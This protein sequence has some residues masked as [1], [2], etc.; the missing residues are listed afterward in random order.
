MFFKPF[1]VL[2]RCHFLK[3]KSKFSKRYIKKALFALIKTV[4]T[5]LLQILPAKRLNAGF[6]QDVRIRFTKRVKMETASFDANFEM[7]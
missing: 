3:I 2:S 4:F 6:Q 7:H 5:H 1:I